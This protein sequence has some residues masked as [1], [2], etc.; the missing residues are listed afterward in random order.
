MATLV[1]ADVGKHILLDRDSTIRG[2]KVYQGEHAMVVEHYVMTGKATSNTTN[3]AIFSAHTMAEIQAGRAGSDPVA[4]L[5]D[6][7]SRVLLGVLCNWNH[8]P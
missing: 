1:P 6:K 2:E 8:G 5:A 4:E 7:W 3:V